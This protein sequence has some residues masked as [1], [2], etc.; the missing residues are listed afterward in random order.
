MFSVERRSLLHCETYQFSIRS[1]EHLTLALPMLRCS[2]CRRLK[3]DC[4]QWRRS[5]SRGSLTAHA[6]PW[7]RN[8]QP[9]I[10]KNGLALHRAF[11]IHAAGDRLRDRTNPLQR[12]MNDSSG[13][14]SAVVGH[15]VDIRNT[16]AVYANDFPQCVT[17]GCLGSGPIF[18]GKATTHLIIQ[19]ASVGIAPDGSLAVR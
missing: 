18:M 16:I 19:Q 11:A 8:G 9:K 17:L 5:L 12:K 15:L 7:M 1:V 14:R 2:S 10:L 6:P 3:S 13:G 4:H